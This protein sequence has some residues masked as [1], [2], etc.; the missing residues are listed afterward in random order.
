VRGAICV[1][2][3]VAVAC[4]GG[5]GPDE[6]PAPTV[7][8]DRVT[9]APGAPQLEALRSEAAR[10]RSAAV[11]RYSGRLAWDDDVTV[12]VYA[13][14]GGRV[15][16]V[17]AAVGDHIASGQILAVISSPDYGQA[18][19]DARAADGALELAQRTLVRV[20]DLYEHGAGPKKDVDAAEEDLARARAEQQRTQ[21]RLRLYGGVDATVDE[22]LRLRSP[23]GGTV[24]ERSL[25]VGQ[26]VRPDQMLA[27][28]TQVGR[29]LF[30]ITDPT[31]LWVWLDVSEVDLATLKLGEVFGLSTAAYP[32]RHFAGRVDLVGASLDPA[33]RT[34][35]VRGSVANPDVALKAEMYVTAE[36]TDVGGPPAGVEVPA[37]ALFLDGDSRWVFVEEAPG[38]FRRQAV[39][40]G[41]E[42]EGWIAVTEGLT[43]SD[44]VVTEGSLLLQQVLD[45]SSKH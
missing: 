12:R 17:K 34:V 6:T 24:A 13:P 41:P 28:E 14:V 15:L 16:E 37:K 20:R 31:R 27:S 3:L 8:G 35:K 44:R 39:R 11:R 30:V 10:P 36:V 23:I 25:A 32:G 21:A 42:R 38:R 45:A 5:A 19:A 29:P 40:V 33:T 2:A 22:L 9:I 4:G 43:A 7:E 18:Q 1:L 26:E